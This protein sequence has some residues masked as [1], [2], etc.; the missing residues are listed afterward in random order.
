M[1]SGGGSSSREG[2]STVCQGGKEG[3]ARKALELNMAWVDGGWRKSL[4]AVGK[5]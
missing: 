3:S 2:A 5:P 4:M 1:D